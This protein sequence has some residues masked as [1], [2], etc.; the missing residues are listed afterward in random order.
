MP[1]HASPMHLFNA[2]S[3]LIANTCVIDHQCSTR[4]IEVLPLLSFSGHN[5][6][7]GSVGILYSTNSG[8]VD[9]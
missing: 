3:Y 1:G 7:E 6:Q 8:R 4:K 9:N 2:C 5:R